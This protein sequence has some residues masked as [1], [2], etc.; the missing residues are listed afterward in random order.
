MPER[1]RLPN[2]DPLQRVPTI[3]LSASLSLEIILQLRGQHCAAQALA[4]SN[5]EVM[6][7]AGQCCPA[8]SAGF[9]GQIVGYTFCLK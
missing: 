9:P 4:G 5:P 2:R 6:T 8:G 7:G 1:F 3:D